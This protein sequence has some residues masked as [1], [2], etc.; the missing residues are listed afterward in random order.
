MIR[1]I[2][3]SVPSENLYTITSTSKRLRGSARCCHCFRPVRPDRACGSCS[4]IICA[5]CI[6]LSYNYDFNLCP[7]CMDESDWMTVPQVEGPAR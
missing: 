4:L 1:Y 2:D 6:N 7:D 5:D 3:A